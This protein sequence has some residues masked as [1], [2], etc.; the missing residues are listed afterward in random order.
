VWRLRFGVV[1]VG[2]WVR[3]RE[4]RVLGVV[5]EGRQEDVVVLDHW[6]VNVGWV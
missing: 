3:V 1:A 6:I 2:I 4:E 5:G